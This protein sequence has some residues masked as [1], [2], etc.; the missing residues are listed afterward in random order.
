MIRPGQIR[1][2]VLW[3]GLAIILAAGAPLTSPR[4]VP[5]PTTATPAL[6]PQHPSTRAQEAGLGV[7][8][9]NIFR[10][11]PRRGTASQT[12]G[13]DPRLAVGISPRPPLRP[14]NFARIAASQPA[15]QTTGT[16]TGTGAGTSRG[17]IC[18]N[19]Q[20]QGRALA[21]IPAKLPGCGLRNPVSVTSVSG[22]R[23]TTAATLSC[24]TAK[25][26]NT[27]VRR[28]VMPAVGNRGGGLAS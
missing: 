11:P 14:G 27:W 24:E 3:L 5:R 26:L 25:A 9:Q 15:R 1:R 6:P 17:A 16:G 12:P 21:A 4:P 19:R 18:G 28:G 23:L 22:V 8:L 20:I 13:Y 7:V 2:P 10:P